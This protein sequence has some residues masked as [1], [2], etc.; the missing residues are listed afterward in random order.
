MDA[1]TGVLRLTTLGQ[2]T[3]ASVRGAPVQSVLAQPKRTALL[4]YLAVARPYGHH[5]R[6]ILLALLWGE[7]DQDSARKALRQSLYFLR[8][9]LGDGVIIANG[10]ESVGISPDHLWCDAVEVEHAL[11]ER[12]FEDAVGLY[13]GNFA[14]GFHVDDAP[15]FER[16]LDTEREWLRGHVLQAALQASLDRESRSDSAGAIEYARRAVEMAPAEEAPAQRL[17]ALLATSGDR[18][19]AWQVYETLKERLWTEYELE[20][21]S[22]TRTLA[23]SLRGAEAPPQPAPAVSTDGH[24]S[25]PDSAGPAHPVPGAP[26]RRLPRRST[27]VMSS[28]L[29]LVILAVSER[30][31]RLHNAR[32][33]LAEAHRLIDAGANYFAAYRLLLEAE[34]ALPNDGKLHQLLVES[35]M[36]IGMTSSPPGA[37]VEVRDFFDTERDW[38][39]LGRTPLA[40]TRLPLGI[41]VWRVSLDGLETVEQLASVGRSTQDWTL[42]PAADNDMVSFPAGLAGLVSAT[43]VPLKPWRLDRLEVTNRRYRDFIEA[44]GY[45]QSEHW[46]HLLAD[47]GNLM[48]GQRGMVDRT[49]RPGP[50]GWEAG[51][52]PA[53]D[54]HHPVS[55]ISWYEAAA[56]CSWAGKRLPTVHHWV[57]AAGFYPASFVARFA[58]FSNNRSVAVGGP[59]AV[60]SSGLYDMAG[61]V[62]E[63]MHNEASPGRRFLMGGGW[64][65]PF[66][67]FTEYD[68]QAPGSRELSFG[69]RCA[70]F[71]ENEGALLESAPPKNSRPVRDPTGRIEQHERNLA[72]DE[73]FRHYLGLYANSPRPLEPRVDHVDVRA[74]D[75]RMEQVSF[76]AGYIG[77]RVPALLFL[78]TRTPP[79]YQTIVYFPGAG[80]FVAE[81][82]FD[83]GEAQRSWFMFVIRSG[84]AVMFPMYRGTYER[85][86]GD[87]TESREAWRDFV[88]HA[89]RDLKRSVDYLLGRPDIDPNRLAYMG[90]SAGASL[91]PVM[92]VIESRFRAAVLLAGG[93]YA[94]PLLPE[95]DPIHFLP[96]MR[97]PTLMF[98]GCF[99]F[100]YDYERS[101]RPFFARIGSAEK[102]HAV[103]EA[104]HLPTSHDEA[105]R[106]ILDWLD[107]HLGPVAGRSAAAGTVTDPGSCPVRDT[108]GI[109]W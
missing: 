40:R 77:E 11:E 55:G 87:V 56:Y 50:A 18:A 108:P 19:S 10:D 61:N 49:G 4:L 107:R 104:G 42:V 106:E 90:M 71:Q 109:A 102:R 76:E 36:M 21:S 81:N 98:N 94:M 8:N 68:A 46:T 26:R 59:Q 92:T 53:G 70:R 63:W 79:P 37:L 28:V 78:P 47:A 103:V 7:R 74:E 54:A 25:T 2:L 1:P 65:E 95:V 9:S 27:I 24:A 20:P 15:E 62:K 32:G 86:R 17:M 13:N 99:D 64:N 100:A 88:V 101:Q 85:Y 89:G 22:Q 35:T 33:N 16:W 96:R 29:L 82:D 80:A 23:A 84:R 39:V 66:Y 67:M 93:H 60:G 3:L 12:R 75:W 6:D 30:W 58:N 38:M 91:G 52:Y 57:N 73:E 14:D 5:Q 48:S 45:G 97:V 31:T 43:P 34:R 41:K 51:A 105:Y 72:Q 44:G 69:V 83:N